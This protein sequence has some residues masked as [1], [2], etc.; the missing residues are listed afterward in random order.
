MADT[1]AGNFVIIFSDN[2]M[3]L[4][5]DNS[6]WISHISACLLISHSSGLA[7][8]GCLYSKH[9]WETKVVSTSRAEGRFVSQPIQ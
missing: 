2:L 8:Q 9:L 3:I 7:F 5:G 1:I 6:P 4:L